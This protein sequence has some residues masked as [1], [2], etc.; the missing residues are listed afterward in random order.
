MSSKRF[1]RHVLLSS[2]CFSAAAI[3]SSLPAMAADV[4]V[5]SGT[6]A[7]ASPITGTDTLTKT[8]SGTYILTAAN[9]S[10]GTTTISAGTLKVGT[11]AP[12]ATI[13]SD[14]TAAIASS[15]IVLNS[16]SSYLVFNRSDGAVST[17]PS[18]TY[19]GV[20]S[21][22]GGTGTTSNAALTQTGYGTLILTGAN[23]YTGS[24]SII[25]QTYTDPT[26]TAKTTYGSVLQIGN[27]GTT[28]S[29]ASQAVYIGAGSTLAFNRSDN[30][31]Y[32]GVLQSSGTVQQ[33]GTGTLTLTGASTAFTGG[34]TIT[35]GTLVLGSTSSFA[36]AGLG[37]VSLGASTPTT[38]NGVFDFSG[39]SGT[40]LIIKSL[41]T[42]AT[43]AN[44][45]SV[46][47]GSKNLT[48]AGGST[49]GGT[50][51]GSGTITIGTTTTGTQ[52]FTND[53]PNFTGSIVIA[54]G[55]TLQY[56]SATSS[57]SLST[58]AANITD[59]GTF[60]FS[61]L[62]SVVYTGVISG[63]GAFKQ[64]G[65]GT[66][67]L[68]A[69]NTFTGATTVSSGTLLIGDATHTTASIAGAASVSSGAVLSGYGSIA[70][71]VTNAGTV[72][73]GYGSV[74]NLTIGGAYTQ[75]GALTSEISPTASSVV[76]VAGK[77]TIAGS[78][79]VVAESGDYGQF[80][81]TTPVLTAS[82]ITGTFTSASGVSGG[83]AYG[84]YYASATEVDA[85][86]IPKTSGQ[87]YGDVV[88]QSIE[89]AHM[90]NDV[91]L[92][93]VGFDRCNDIGAKCR[94]WTVW[95]QDVVG[96]NHVDAANGGAAFN[97][98]SW[99]GIGGIGYTFSQEGSLN[100][101]VSYNGHTV[102]V[103]G[104]KSK[105]DTD[106]IYTSLTL[107]M[108]GSMIGM[109]LNGFYTSNKTDV[110]RDTG[111]NGMA[112]SNF[113]STGGGF[114]G[115]I[116]VPLLG[117]DLTPVAKAVYAFMT[118]GPFTETG[119]PSLNFTGIH[120]EQTTGYYD[121]GIR[122]SHTF[123]T[124][125]GYSLRPYVYAGVQVNSTEGVPAVSMS[126]VDWA[127]TS[128]TSSSATPDKFSGVLKV[129]LDA[130]LDENFSFQAGLNGKFG[131]KQDQEVFTLSGSYRF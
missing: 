60:A 10:T 73:A 53:S 42:A 13:V 1:L 89:N 88:T 87:I 97:G 37:A 129:G 111:L 20:I 125:G 110:S 106:G 55:S 85:L 98:H 15:S 119:A 31:T 59:N 47:M 21:G 81:Y 99:G 121:A 12:G 64:A 58:M 118:Y 9:T 101:A 69:I 28:G 3:V 94:G 8:T 11:F 128:F 78:M 72:R 50:I 19:A 61:R 82:S 45:S 66:V 102:G 126:L 68:N 30:V 127:N 57:G 93:H 105:A 39:I 107:H 70:G 91:V 79:S 32:S 75:T 7:V 108:G 38:N 67:T 124:D 90:I 114:S 43:T 26:T 41:A 86:I 36:A 74:G 23:T 16:A 92:D 4:P 2:C 120:G 6:Q 123:K 104:G 112:S 84:V 100:L 54:S 83:V 52:I 27:G 77:A 48:L 40:T 116:T 49:Y 51:T 22:S 18:Y 113:S 14:T 56:G 24:T 115:Q 29:I 130:K 76:K 65:S 71:A 95:V 62:D 109:D 33:L 17:A 35:T 44:S 96:M 80:A 46:L 25:S 103:A 131:S 63:T 5:T 117:G 34:L 122:G